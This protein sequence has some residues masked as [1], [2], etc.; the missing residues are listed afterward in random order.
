MQVCPTCSARL[1]FTMHGC[2]RVHPTG[3]TS[4]ARHA[5][6][7]TCSAHLRLSDVFGTSPAHH[8]W[9]PT[10][11]SD[12]WHIYGSSCTVA[13]VFSTS[14]ALHA[15]LPTCSVRLRLVMHGCRR[16]RYV[17]GSSCT[18][19]DLFGCCAPTQV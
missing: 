2:L 7:P 1:P 3:G 5:R 16:A 6:L 4:T 19:A 18:V 14:T 17:C 9:L 15:G 10:C 8:A 11:S 12:G 13:D